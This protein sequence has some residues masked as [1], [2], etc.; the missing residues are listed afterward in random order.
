VRRAV[1]LPNQRARADARAVDALTSKGIRQL[2][3]GFWGVRYFRKTQDGSGWRGRAVFRRARR[4]DRCT[5]GVG[6]KRAGLCGR[7]CVP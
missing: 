3:E 1:A 4:D 6:H 2:G 5:V 7:V